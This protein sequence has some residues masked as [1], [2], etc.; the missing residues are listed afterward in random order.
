M[1]PGVDIL[2][3]GT[4]GRTRERKWMDIRDR[5]IDGQWDFLSKAKMRV[6]IRR[7][8]RWRQWLLL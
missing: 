5:K 6:E 4:L 1:P 7:V 3:A 8:A 2:G